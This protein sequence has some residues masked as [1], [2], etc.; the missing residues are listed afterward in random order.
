MFNGVTPFKGRR[1]V[2]V[3]LENS[4]ITLNV[5]LLS[6]PPNKSFILRVLIHLLHQKLMVLWS[7]SYKIQDG[8]IVFSCMKLFTFK[9]CHI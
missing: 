2:E 6:Q 3:S 9:T 5:T 8:F 7:T 4:S 1:F